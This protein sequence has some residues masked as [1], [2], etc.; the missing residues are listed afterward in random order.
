MQWGIGRRIVEPIIDASI[1]ITGAVKNLQQH[2]LMLD[3]NLSVEGRE[4]YGTLDYLIKCNQ[5]CNRG[6]SPPSAGK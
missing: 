6:P 1:C 3:T 2:E 5:V 4:A